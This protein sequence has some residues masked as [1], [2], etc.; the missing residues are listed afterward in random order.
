MNGKITF[1][2]FGK[3]GTPIKEIG[4]SKSLLFFLGFL[5]ASLAAAIG[6]GIHDYYSLKIASF[7]KR[8]LE[9]SVGDYEHEIAVQREQIQAFASEIN[10][11]KSKVLTLGDFEKQ[12]RIIAGL[13]NS[14]HSEVFGIG[15][16]IPD[17][18]DTNIALTEKHNT[19]IREMH[20]QVKQIELASVVREESFD[21]LIQ[22]L[23]DK[24]NLL[25]HTPAIRP[26]T[27]IPT[28]LF[29]NR[30]SP[31]TGLSEFHKGVDIANRQG[32]EILAT[33]DGVVTFADEK[34]CWGRLIV[35]SH[36]HGMTTHYAHLKKFFK[37]SGD[38]VKRGEVIAKMGSTGRSTGPHLHYEVRLNNTP[39]NPEK[40][41]LN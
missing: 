32:T 21:S 22:D 14:G 28:S 24:G 39:V 20:D 13:D 26:T 23:V 4:F 17:D 2:V 18:M 12:I 29:G 19:L 37:K 15:G 1:I 6:V 8:E 10:D 34:G 9:S 7:D 41:I 33:A 16:S 5:I 31:F 40:Y 35:I 27:G 25:A 11:L 30:V 36:G 38:T 3:G